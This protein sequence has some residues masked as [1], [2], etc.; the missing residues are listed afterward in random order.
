MT[1][2]PL[3]DAYQ[4]WS[5]PECGLTERTRPHPPNATRFHVCPRLHYLTAPL[6]RAGSDC[7]LVANERG[8]Y[9]GKEIQQ[10]GDDGR[11]YMSV[12]TVYGDGRNDC[13]VFAPLARASLE[14]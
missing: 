12:Y 5:C 14:V 11:P 10:S 7:K 8:D 1:A 4:D 9:L 2:V 3:L 6:V 13:A